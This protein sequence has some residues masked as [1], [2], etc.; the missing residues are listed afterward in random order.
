MISCQT[1]VFAALGATVKQFCPIVIFWQHSA[2]TEPHTLCRADSR[3][4]ML[5]NK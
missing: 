5:L 4:Q 3:H 2:A 1:D